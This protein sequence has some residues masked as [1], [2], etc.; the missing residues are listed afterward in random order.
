MYV[1]KEVAQVRQF[2]VCAVLRDITFT[3]E[4]YESFID[5]QEKLH[6]NICRRRSL[7]AIG[8]HDLDTIEGPFTYEALAPKDI[9]FVPLAQDKSYD[10]EGLFEYYKTANSPLKHFLH[11]IEGSPGY[12][13]VMDAKDR[14]LSL[15]PIINGEHS[16]ISAQTKNVLIECTCT[17]ITK[18]K[19][20]LNTIIAM[21]SQYSSTPF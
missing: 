15:P 14:V 17:D 21:F 16:R 5:L 19:I 6:V 13:V 2:V 10:A 9:N 12:P 4:S 18:G 20:V 7:V 1:K 8:T 3:K 11:I